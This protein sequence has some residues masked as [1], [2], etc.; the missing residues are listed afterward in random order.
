VLVVVVS[1]RALVVLGYIRLAEQVIAAHR[2]TVAG[3]HG[4]SASWWWDAS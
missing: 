1:Q 3:L 2:A 4:M